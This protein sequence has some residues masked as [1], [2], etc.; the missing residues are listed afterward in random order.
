MI[1]GRHIAAE[2]GK[3]WCSLAHVHYLSKAMFTLKS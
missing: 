1:V 2:M 3:L